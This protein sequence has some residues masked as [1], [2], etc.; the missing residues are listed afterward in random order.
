MPLNQDNNDKCKLIQRLITSII[1][2]GY[3]YSNTHAP[4]LIFD[5]NGFNV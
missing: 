2:L 4:T 5:K 3:D 1:D